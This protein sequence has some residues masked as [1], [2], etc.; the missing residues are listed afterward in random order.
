MVL[1][2]KMRLGDFRFLENDFQ[3]DFFAVFNLIFLGEK[4][5]LKYFVKSHLNLIYS[6]IYVYGF[7]P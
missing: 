5:A 4:E 3:V 2:D 1:W 6:D 7:G